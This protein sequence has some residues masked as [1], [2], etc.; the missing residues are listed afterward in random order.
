[1]TFEEMSIDFNPILRVGDAI[2]DIGVD[3][4]GNVQKSFPGWWSEVANAWW[5]LHPKPSFYRHAWMA[6]FN[7]LEL[8]LETIDHSDSGVST[9]DDRHYELIGTGWAL[10]WALRVGQGNKFAWQGQNQYLGAFMGLLGL[11]RNAVFQGDRIQFERE[12]LMLRIV[13]D[14]RQ[15]TGR[16]SQ[17]SNG[18]HMTHPVPV[19]VI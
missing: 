13:F 10:C 11:V 6:D 12:I 4:G 2:R 17:F 3:M 19:R 7:G 16:S 8:G 1:M 9:I 15:M 14:H 18:M 5:D